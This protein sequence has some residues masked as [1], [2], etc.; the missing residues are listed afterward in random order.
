MDITSVIVTFMVTCRVLPR[1]THETSS[2]LPAIAPS[3][4]KLVNLNLFL[5]NRFRTLPFSVCCNSFICH[6]Y[7]NT[8]GVTSH[9]GT[10]RL[11]PLAA[12]LISLPSLSHWRL[13][14]FQRKSPPM[15]LLF[16]PLPNVFLRNE[17]RRTHPLPVSAPCLHFDPALHVGIQHIQRHRPILKHRIVK[18]PHIK[19]RAQLFLR[20]R[21]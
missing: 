7:G 18:P 10:P 1:S 11:P 20:F 6:S 9:S 17:Q 4:A 5:F 3:L 16:L 8:G 15:S 19:F 21:P 14:V 2:D 13:I 12:P